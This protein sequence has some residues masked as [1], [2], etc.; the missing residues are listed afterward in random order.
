M[1]YSDKKSASSRKSRN[2]DAESGKNRIKP[3]KKKQPVIESSSESEL[4]VSDSEVESELEIRAKSTARTK[5]KPA[6]KPKAR[7]QQAQ[8]NEDAGE[9]PAD[10]DNAASATNAGMTMLMAIAY[11]TGL[12]I[13]SQPLRSFYVPDCYALFSAAFF[14]MEAVYDN[15]LLH[16][17]RAGF[18]SLGFFLYVGHLFYYHIL[19]VRDATGNLTRVERRCLRRYA[20]IGSPDAWTVPAPLSG[21]LASYGC[22]TPPSK[23][24]GKIVPRLPDL[25]PLS[26]GTTTGLHNLHAVHGISRVPII[27]A[28]QLFFRNFGDSTIATFLE[29][30][31][32]PL[33]SATLSATAHFCGIAD[34]RAANNPFQVLAF[35][36]GWNSPSERE[37]NFANY[38]LDHK[39]TIIRR[40]KVPDV[41]D[42]VAISDLEKFL[43]FT[44]GASDEWMKTLLSD[45][46]SLSK[47]F[48]GSSTLEKVD[49]NTLEEFASTVTWSVNPARTMAANTWFHG[50]RNWRHAL[51]GKVNTEQSGMLY[52]AVISASPHAVWTAST[53]PTNHATAGSALAEGPYFV[54]AP[55]LTLVENSSQPDPVA[56]L[57]TYIEQHMY[58]N[59]G[60]RAART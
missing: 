47:F 59:L 33:P 40:I 30:V 9:E 42:N 29:D 5:T 10:D 16:E 6:R 53:L 8:A 48:P 4:S 28:M 26:T 44:D 55:P 24:Y 43:G 23:Y 22:I 51:D 35:N 25:S 54:D 36:A 7:A 37:F 41:P 39:R 38:D 17:T 56:N 15:S 11:R 13:T 50:R 1:P 21:I 20:Q 19:R 14:M 60:G 18:T 45:A 27:P 3:S 58:D 2:Y 49:V 34:S 52:K 46:S 12:A 32:H 31:L 57:K